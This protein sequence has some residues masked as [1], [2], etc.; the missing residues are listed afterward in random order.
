[1]N[2]DYSLPCKSTNYRAGRTSSVKY[3]VLHYT[4]ND[5]S[6]AWQNAHYFNTSRVE[7]SAHYFI[8]N[9]SVYASVPEG[10]TAWA[11]GAKYGTAPYWGKCTNANSISIEM[12]TFGG[13][14]QQATVDKA[15]ELTKSLMNKYGVPLENVLRHYDVCAKNCPA[16]W[17]GNGDVLWCFFKLMVAGATGQEIQPAPQASNTDLNVGDARAFLIACGQQCANDFVGHDKIDVDGVV[18]S[19]TRRMAIRVL[20]HAMNL[21]Y[22]AGLDEDG[23]KG[24]LTNRAMNGHYVKKG[25]KQYLV[26][27]MEIFAYLHGLDAKGVEYPGTYGSGLANALGR[28]HCDENFINSYS[29]L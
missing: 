19:D 27:A 12:C 9:D 25:E 3:I 5:G 21:D 8:D 2:I 6:T 24:N 23:K 22:K 15:V 14:I 11:V 29:E 18:G 4:G 17:V 16:P 26:T 10:D 13:Q 28:E 1:M 7:A 20:Q